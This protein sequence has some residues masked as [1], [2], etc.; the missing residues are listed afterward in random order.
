MRLPTKIISG[1]VFIQAS[2]RAQYDY[3]DSY[4]YSYDQTGS[5]GSVLQENSAPGQ[6]SDFPSSINEAPQNNQNPNPK[7]LNN[8]NKNSGITSSSIVPKSGTTNV[9]IQNNNNKY[10][11]FKN[12]R[13]TISSP[14]SLKSNTDYIMSWEK[15][16]EDLLETTKI[17]WVQFQGQKKERGQSDKYQL[18]VNN[19]FELTIKECDF[20]DAGNYQL[21][22]SEVNSGL[23]KKTPNIQIIVLQKPEQPIIKKANFWQDHGFMMELES[24]SSDPNTPI[25]IARCQTS[26]KPATKHIWNV[27]LNGVLIRTIEGE[28]AS[29]QD[30]INL[31]TTD[32]STLKLK[33][34]REMQNW[35]FSCQAIY[36]INSANSMYVSYAVTENQSKSLTVSAEL[37][38]PFEVQF[39]PDQPK[40][41]FNSTSS[42]G[43]NSKQLAKQN[44][45]SGQFVCESV[46]NP[47]AQYK[48]RIL[49]PGGE[50]L[51]DFD[52]SDRNYISSEGWVDELLR[53]DRGFIK[54]MEQKRKVN[55]APEVI[56]A[57]N[58]VSNS[59]TTNLN[60]KIPTSQNVNSA[61]QIGNS[62]VVDPYLVT[63]EMK[64]QIVCIVKNKHGSKTI[65]KSINQIMTVEK[66]TFFDKFTDFFNKITETAS[67]NKL[68]FWIVLGSSITIVF[69]LIIVCCCSKK[70]MKKNP[71]DT[72][73]DNNEPTY[74]GY[75]TGTVGSEF[76]FHHNQHNQNRG[77]RNL[78]KT[79][80][81]TDKSVKRRI[82]E[83][84][85]DKNREFDDDSDDAY[86]NDQDQ[87]NRFLVGGNNNQMNNQVIG[88]GC[89]E[90]V[91]NLNSLLHHDFNL[92]PIASLSKKQTVV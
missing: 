25:E 58:S 48:F 86:A 15:N 41:F 68:L 85:K 78:S 51:K 35:M 70:C 47:V 4:S 30:E 91:K 44:T 7:I 92:R 34:T 14:T 87:E 73:Y 76:S 39:P 90:D 16:S 55:G 17:G 84:T 8:N 19:L 22:V 24:E 9:S 38:S 75:G 2:S 83:I 13:L 37:D 69:C 80:R 82:A 6:N 56:T 18:N 11:C 20:S 57:A 29:K 59:E 43:K 31:V 81:T 1:L 77:N 42:A 71:N 89:D 26:S 60:Y 46:S 64:S 49:K 52:F 62:N 21:D 33:P 65:S 67:S 61:A 79:S 23:T 54:E 50:S 5:I 3:Q 63:E 28:L 45:N 36:D 10:I 74:S 53:L 32:I 40:L 27:H 12:S 66:A 72:S 88:R